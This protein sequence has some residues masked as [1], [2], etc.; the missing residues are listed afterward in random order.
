MWIRIAWIIIFAMA[1][2]VAELLGSE[3]TGRQV[4]TDVGPVVLL[5]VNDNFQRANDSYPAG[6]VFRVAAGVHL[7]QR[8]VNP[9]RGNQWIGEKGAV[10]DGE[11]GLSDAFHGRAN[12]ITLEGL[13]LRNYVDN[14]IYLSSGSQVAINQVTVSDTG[15]GDGESNGAIRLLNISNVSVTDCHFTRVSSG[16]LPTKCEGPIRIE[17]NAG[18]N[19]GRNFVQ[20]DSCTGGGIRVRYNSMERIGDYLR[21]GAQDVEDWISVYKVSGLRSDPAQFNYNRARGHGPSKSG[22]FIML[23]DGGGQYLEAI[24]NVGVT[25]GQVGI[26]L[27]GGEHI[28]VQKNLMYSEVWPESNIAFYS[29]NYSQ[30]AECGHHRIQGNRANWMNRDSRQSTFWTDDS[31]QPLIVSEN[32]FPDRTLSDKIWDLWEEEINQLSK[33]SAV[34]DSQ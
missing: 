33:M 25:P 30:P 28:N 13:E 23:G 1:M 18:V 4:S 24:G 21:R 19:I 7:K 26:G 15:S 27:C 10:L 9:K 14:G 29:C 17:W 20:L 16:V 5:K 11:N 22:S 12:Q 8:V 34:G 3:T 2:P 6:T 32:K 31:T